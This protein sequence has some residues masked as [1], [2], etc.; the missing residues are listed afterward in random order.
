M[1]PP[2]L[3]QVLT[4]RRVDEVMERLE[5]VE[6]ETEGFKEYATCQLVKFQKEKAQDTKSITELK[7]DLQRM[8]ERH[9]ELEHLLK[10]SLSKLNLDDQSAT[11]ANNENIEMMRFCSE[12][13]D[14]SADSMKRMNKNGIETCA[15]DKN[16]DYL[17]SKDLKKKFSGKSKESIDS[18][19]REVD[20]S[21]MNFGDYDIIRNALRS[22]KGIAQMRILNLF[23]KQEELRVFDWEAM[24]EQLRSDFHTFQKRKTSSNIKQGNK[25]PTL[26]YFMQMQKFWDSRAKFN[27]SK[28][29]KEAEFLAGANKRTLENYAFYERENPDLQFDE[30]IEKIISHENKLSLSKTKE[31]MSE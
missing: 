31:I 26:I 27:V 20:I 14:N 7:Q 23:K 30:I 22:S 3:R 10:S 15:A 29:M 12:V 8:V 9:A 19:I 1:L 11:Q 18:W 21:C 24:K 6:E 4:E 13:A 2:F 28:E 17:R 5:N 16:F 25:E